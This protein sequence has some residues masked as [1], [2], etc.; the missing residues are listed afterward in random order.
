MQCKSHLVLALG[1]KRQDIAPCHNA[2]Q[3]PGHM[4]GVPV[5]DEVVQMLA[6]AVACLRQQ[7]QDKLHHHPLHKASWCLRNLAT[8]MLCCVT[9]VQSCRQCNDLIC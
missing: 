9:K 2:Q 8:V 4:G 5:G 6:D 1:C 7:L 3:S